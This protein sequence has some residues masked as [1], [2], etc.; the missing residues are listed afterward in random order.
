MEKEFTIIWT[1]A[2][3]CTLRYGEL[4]NIQK[5]KIFQLSQTKQKKKNKEKQK[6]M[7]NL[8]QPTIL[9]IMFDI[10]FNIYSHIKKK[11]NQVN[12]RTV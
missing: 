9:L 1:Q 7:W 6:K 3:I 2:A 4:L 11:Y 5:A 10:F 8:L 12:F